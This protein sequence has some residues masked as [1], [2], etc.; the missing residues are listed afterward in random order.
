MY[1]VMD[2][3]I[4]Q[5]QNRRCVSVPFQLLFIY[6][7]HAVLSF[8]Q[9]PSYVNSVT[10]PL[11]LHSCRNVC[12]AQDNVRS[13]YDKA[14]TVEKWHALYDITVHSTICGTLEQEI[15]LLF[16]AGHFDSVENKGCIKEAP[17]F[18]SVFVSSGN[19]LRFY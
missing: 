3:V 6:H 18:I 13:A 9:R 5:S 19:F 17:A 11:D 16:N 10:P 4:L 12:L 14:T 2:V 1:E 8:S 15:N 7:F